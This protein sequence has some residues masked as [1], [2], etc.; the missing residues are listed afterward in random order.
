MLPKLDNL[1]LLAT[2]MSAHPGAQRTHHPLAGVG[3]HSQPPP[4]GHHPQHSYPAPYAYQ[5]TSH[6]PDSPNSPIHVD[7][8]RATQGGAV[9]GPFQPKRAARTS[10]VFDGTDDGSPGAEGDGAP[11]RKRSKQSLSCGECKRRKIKCDRKIPCSS[12][13]KR[14]Q[15]DACSWEDAKIEP[16]KQPF[17]LATDVQELRERLQLVERFIDKLPAPL[18]AS[19]AELGVSTMGQRPK[20]ELNAADAPIDY[21]SFESAISKHPAGHQSDDLGVIDNIIFGGSGKFANSGTTLMQ[22]PEP[23]FTA[24]RTSILAPR[25][26]FVSPATSTNLGL[27]LCLNQAELDSERLRTLDKIFAILPP[28][29]EAYDSAQRYF[30]SFDWFFP[31]IHRETFFAELERYWQMCEAGK[32]HEVDPAWLALYTIILALSC[33]ESMAMTVVSSPEERCDWKSQ[34]ASYHAASQKLLMLADAFGR[35]Q[36]RA[37]QVTIL[38]ACWTMVSAYGGE[39][40]RF[41]S[42]LAAA[43]RTGQ[44]LGLHQL[45][46]DPE[47]MPPDDPAWPPGKNSLKRETALRLWGHLRFFDYLAASARF[48]AYA[49]NPTHT[50]TAFLSNLNWSDLSMDDWRVNPAPNNILTDASLERQKSAMAMINRKT[51]D[52]LIADENGFNYGTILEIDKEYRELLANIPD[53]F[54]HEYVSLETK[55]PIIRA[56][57]YIVLQGTHNRL[58]RLHR[59]FLVKGWEP[60]SKFAYSTDACIRAAKIV[61]ISHHNNININRNL[62]MMYSHSLTSAIVLAADLYHAIDEGCTD[63]ELESKKEVLAMSLEIFSEDIEKKVASHHLRNIIS[64]ARKVLSGLLFEQEKRR[65]RR[66]ARMMSG[67]SSSTERSFAEILQALARELEPEQIAASSA[68]SV[69]TVPV[70]AMSSTSTPVSMPSVN[71]GNAAILA[72]PN[73][74]TTRSKPDEALSSNTYGDALSGS[75]SSNLL[76][77][78]G[79]INLGGQTWDYWS[80]GVVSTGAGS[81]AAPAFSFDPQAFGASMTPG[82][83]ESTEQTTQAL[84]QQLVGGW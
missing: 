20:K 84:L 31:V 59:P 25:I 51:F 50:N 10:G 16:E 48:K 78:M 58:V 17:A 79:L 76:Q 28:K 83:S 27:D 7:V 56:K 23:D 61:L 49:I 52:L 41:S 63:A 36:V 72:T 33:D 43:I 53:V 8:A 73:L 54:Q 30:E 3:H 64:S 66:L 35:P 55:D 70:R 69:G 67:D 22:L 21:S 40:G 29:R 45:G 44:R 71:P 1:E 24:W 12:C 68:A 38:F 2:V 5:S 74:F 77:D 46:S 32:R 26:I 75:F 39:F 11:A 62:R 65:A 47:V 14:N 81:A 9:A 37:I 13:L 6:S 80:P 42:W 15:P 18:K 82:A 19:F 60:N 4:S 57:R 34:G